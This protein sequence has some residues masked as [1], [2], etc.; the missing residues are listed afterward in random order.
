MSRVADLLGSSALV[1]AHACRGAEQ[2]RPPWWRRMRVWAPVSV[3]CVPIVWAAVRAAAGSWVPIGDDAYFTARSRDVLTA[4]HPLLGAWSS[5]SLDLETPINNL[6]PAQLDLLAPFTRFAP[7]GGTAVGVALINVVAIVVVAWLIARIAGDHAVLPAMCAVGLLT[8][9][10]GSEMLITPRQHQAM[11]L[12]YLCMLVAAWAVTAGDRWAIAPAVAA[13]SL[14]AQTHLSYPVLAAAMAMVMLV[15]QV[16]TTR[17]G[18]AVGGRRPFVVAGVLASVLWVQ[19]VVDQFAGHGNLGHVVFGSGDAGRA[20]LVR[21]ARIVAGTLVSPYTFVRPG[22]REF[23]AAAPFASVWQSIVFWL[24]VG[25]A[26][27][28]ITVAIKRRGLRHAAGSLVATVAVLAGVLDAA[29]LPRTTFG[30]TIMNYRWLWATAAFVLMVA[31]V[32][33]AR[34][35]GAHDRDRRVRTAVVGLAVTVL[36]VPALANLPRS[37]QNV[38]ADRYLA[39][40]RNITDALAQVRGVLD[41]IAIDGPI[42]VDDSAMYFGHGYTYP[43]LAVM[44][45]HRVDFRFDDAFQERR[46]GSKR[47]SDGTEFQRLRLVSGNPAIALRDDPNAVAFVGGDLPVVFVLEYK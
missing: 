23:D 43:L 34:W 17:E 14:V 9:T 6:G 38:G 18:T 4:H 20:G 5:G 1:S 35:A 28:W 7:M 11:I 2:V 32:A 41:D 12:P 45:E 16:V 10:M 24:A 39:E 8:W 25:F 29:L 13:G 30:Y 33:V 26:I 15:G 40:Q 42:V 31:F 37:V 47:V 27:G 22:Y 46:F 21:G 19:S 44:Q 3:V 36:V